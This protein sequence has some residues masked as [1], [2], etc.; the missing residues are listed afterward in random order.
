[1]KKILT[2][3]FLTGISAFALEIVK[4]D[5]N[6]AFVKVSNNSVNKI[7]FPSNIT[8]KSYSAEKGIQIEVNKNEL[9]VKYTPIV[10]QTQSFDGN[11][12]P[13]P[14]S[15]KKIAYSKAIP[16]EVFVATETGSYLLI[17]VPSNM[18]AE[19]IKILDSTAD[20]KK[21]LEYESKEPHADMMISLTKSAFNLATGDGTFA[22]DGFKVEE[23]KAVGTPFTADIL[24]TPKYKIEGGNYTSLV[25]TVKN[26]SQKTLKKEILPKVFSRLLIKNKLSIS[27][28][29]NELPPFQTTYLVI[30]VKREETEGGNK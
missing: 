9:Y 17:L 23:V 28:L 27:L 10:E 2:L 12:K 20:R 13:L 11:N 25:F 21:A 18:E 19:T 5:G 8:A 16:A 15:D 14:L 3:T 30:N 4:Y 22:L 29:D 26:T 24:L 1:M 7:E 6:K